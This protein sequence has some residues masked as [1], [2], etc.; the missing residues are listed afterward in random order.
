MCRVKQPHLAQPS[1]MQFWA[2]PSIT[3]SIKPT[4]LSPLLLMAL[5]PLSISF[6]VCKHITCSSNLQNHYFLMYFLF[7]NTVLNKKN[8]KFKKRQFQ[9][10]SSKVVTTN[11]NKQKK[12]QPLSSSWQQGTKITTI[13]GA[14]MHWKKEGIAFHGR[15][16][17]PN[18]NITL[19]CVGCSR[20]LF[21]QSLH[22]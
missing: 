20:Q 5:L 14:I 8:S 15:N 21:L 1:N 9:T 13:T 2:S 11:K 18:K 7:K 17:P 4:V 16:E 3:P 6:P 19:S 10:C 22:L 12:K